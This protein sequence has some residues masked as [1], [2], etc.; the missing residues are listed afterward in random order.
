MKSSICAL[1]LFCIVKASAGDINKNNNAERPNII[2]ILADDLGVGEIGLFPSDNVHGKIDTPNVDRLGLEGIQFTNAYAGYTVCA[3]SRTSLFTG[4]HS[5]NFLKHNLSGTAISPTEI[6]TLPHYLKSVGYNTAL[7]G[8]SAPLTSPIESGFDYFIGQIDQSACHN[9]YPYQ[10]DYGTKQK[11]ELKLN[12]ENKRSRENCMS[13]PSLFNYTVDI[14]QSHSID[15]IHS[16]Y[17]DTNPFFLYMAFTVPHAGG[18]GSSP[19]DPEQGAPV[20][21]D[22]QYVNESWPNVEK[23]HAAVISYL[24]NYVGEVIHTLKKLN[25]DDN[26]LIIFASD[27]GAHLEGGHNYKFFNSTGGLKGHKRS[28]FEGGV[29]SPTLIRWPSVVKPN[30]ISGVHF[31]FF[32]ILPTLCD[33]GGCLH[34]LPDDLDGISI[35]NEL[36]GLP[37]REHEYIMF[38]WKG[39]GV[40]PIQSNVKK[41]S[42]SGY[43]VRVGDWKGVVPFCDDGITNQPSLN[44]D[45]QLFDLVNDP[46]EK[47]DVSNLHKDVVVRLKKLII[48]KQVSC[49]CY[50]CGAWYDGIEYDS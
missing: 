50:Q 31:G 21:S 32:D 44:D 13:N 42:K 9:M 41:N 23:D 39:L 35:Y 2:F 43:S 37:Q 27:N 3:P 22:L 4:R 20:P 8:K 12:Q 46:F 36:K 48:S 19:D 14:T 33:I 26:T 5:G 15:W 24:D 34:L 29:R 16:I 47:S 25:I 6:K 49:K 30:R 18:W 38:T 7:V 45:M 1:L 40:P 11:L 28:L 17:Q 10:I